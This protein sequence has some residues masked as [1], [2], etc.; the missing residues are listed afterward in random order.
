MENQEGFLDENLVLDSGFP[1]I[2]FPDYGISPPLIQEMDEFD[3]IDPSFNF[4]EHM[5]AQNFL[6]RSKIQLEYSIYQVNYD[7]KSVILKK[8]SKT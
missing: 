3:P 6:V 2:T 5:S 4:T 7:K 1:I 8:T